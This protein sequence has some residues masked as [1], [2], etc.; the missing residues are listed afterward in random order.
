VILGR[1]KL[2]SPEPTV[3]AR[4]IKVPTLIMLDDIDMMHTLE[5]V[6]CIEKPPY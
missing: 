6:V 3:A 5:Y 4:G 1:S 2:V